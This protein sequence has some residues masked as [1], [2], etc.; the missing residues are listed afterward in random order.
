VNERN[1][2]VRVAVDIGGTFTDL[3]LHD[4]RTGQTFVWKTPSTPADPSIG[5]LEGLHGITR[6]AGIPLSDIGMILHG[7]TIATNAVLERKLPKGALI[8]TDGFRDVLEIGRHMRKDVYTLK[9]E[10]RPLLIPRHLRFGVSE[11]V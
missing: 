1:T 10:T 4:S 7:S 5:L 8:T 9:A 11:R 3:H 6:T 2:D